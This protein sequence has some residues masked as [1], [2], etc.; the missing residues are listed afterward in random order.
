MD[1]IPAIDLMSG[2]CVRLIQG[3]YHRQITYHDDP[4]KQAREFLQAGAKWLHV[5]DLDG[6][7]IGKPFNVESIGK[8]AAAVEM[9]IEVG[10]GI[11]D[12][13]SIKQMLDVGVRRVIIG[14]RAVSDFEWFSEMAEKFPDKLVLGLDAKGS[15]VA[16]HG[17]TQQAPQ[18]LLEFAVQAAELPISAIIY[19][20]ISKDGMMA[21]PNFGRT[22]TLIDVVDI[23]VV[24]SGGVTQIE[25]AVKL[26]E[27][28]A[29]A[30]IVGRA[31][32]EGSVKL[33]DMIKAVESDS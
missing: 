24:A 19:T 1:V 31:L 29:A 4:V 27:A 18:N 11:R 32:Y 14:T 8:I 30:A 23:D 16:T 28:G 22:K 6:A 3:Q 20:D 5:I 33:E 12:E 25:D 15:K 7:R 21:G 2:K 9:N 10:G 17:W 26:N 13:E